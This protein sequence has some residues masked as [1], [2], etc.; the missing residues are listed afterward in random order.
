[1]VLKLHPILFSKSS[2]R[3]FSL[4][5]V[6]IHFTH[7]YLHTVATVTGTE[8]DPNLVNWQRIETKVYKCGKKLVIIFHRVI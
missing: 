8:R 5:A 2:S 4:L 3:A 7:L 6:L 1:M